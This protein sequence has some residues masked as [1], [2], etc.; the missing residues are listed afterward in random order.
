LPRELSSVLVD[1]CA[2]R[3]K[4]GPHGSKP[5]FDDVAAAARRLGLPLREVARRAAL[6]GDQ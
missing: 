4:S 5:E 2:V 6:G 3:V 1:G